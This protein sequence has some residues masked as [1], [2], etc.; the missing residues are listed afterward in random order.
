[1]IWPGAALT[2]QRH[3]HLDLV[4][5]RRRIP[6]VLPVVGA[7]K[8]DQ[9]VASFHRHEDLVLDILTGAHVD[10]MQQHAA[11]GQR[12]LE[13]TSLRSRARRVEW[14]AWRTSGSAAQLWRRGGESALAPSF[15]TPLC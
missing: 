4:V 10:D 11:L 7:A 13:L 9:R 3:T 1:M 15:S 5:R 8:H 14:G 12:R 6:R 2:C